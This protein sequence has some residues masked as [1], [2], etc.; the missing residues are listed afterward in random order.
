MSDG[1]NQVLA[2]IARVDDRVGRIEEPIDRMDGRIGR[3][4]ERIDRMDER[5]DRMDERTGRLEEELTRARVE[6]M[7]RLDR[8]QDVLAGIRDDIRV[9]VAATD[10]VRDRHNAIRNDYDQLAH[11]VSVIHRRLIQL[12]QRVDRGGSGA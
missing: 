10:M 9:N 4:A 1:I 2:A 8:Q 3:I 11:Q 5:I 6:V 12:E 7:A